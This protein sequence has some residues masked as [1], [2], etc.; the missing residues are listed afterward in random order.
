LVP[1]HKGTLK[2]RGQIKK[3]MA[4]FRKEVEGLIWIKV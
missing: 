1:Q 3:K 4:V 2:L